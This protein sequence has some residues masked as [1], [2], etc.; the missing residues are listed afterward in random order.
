M[1]HGETL[2]RAIHADR[3]RD[4]DRAARDRRLLTR[5]ADVVPMQ[6]RERRTEPGAP[7]PAAPC[8]G[9]AGVPA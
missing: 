7:I 3:V 6:P 5:P 4:L 9:S 8:G 1:F 2:A